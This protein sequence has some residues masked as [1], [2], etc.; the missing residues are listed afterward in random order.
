MSRSI[1][2]RAGFD[3]LFTVQFIG[4]M[5]G[6]I[7]KMAVCSIL[8]S[9]GGGN[10]AGLVPYVNALFIL[11]FF[12]FSALAGEICDRFPGRK[13]VRTVKLLE[14]P[15]SL[16]AVWSA[17]SGSTVMMLIS[18]FLY[19]TAATFFSPA[20]Y[21]LIPDNAGKE[22]LLKANAAVSASTYVSI[23]LGLFIGSF[24]A[25]ESMRLTAVMVLPAV[26]LVSAAASFLVRSGSGTKSVRV[27]ANFLR[28]LFTGLTFGRRDWRIFLAILGCSWFWLVASV[29]SIMFQT[30]PSLIFSMGP[31]DTPAAVCIL[32]VSVAAGVAGGSV[33]SSVLLKGRIS[34]RLVPVSALFTAAFL[35]DAALVCLGESA[36]E[37]TAL[38][39]ALRSFTFW[40]TAAD[41]FL[42]AFGGSMFMVPLNTCLQSLPKESE[43]ARVIASGNIWNSLFMVAGSLLCSLS[44]VSGSL[45]AA[46]ITVSLVTFLIAASSAFFI[47]RGLTRKAALLLLR[48][49][50]G[51]RIAGLP[52]ELLGKG[53][54]III[55]NH[56]SLLDGAILW[57]VL[58]DNTSFAIDRSMTGIWWVKPFLAFS[59]FYRV[60]PG[61]GASLRSL[62]E[63]VSSGKN[64]VIFPEGRITVT[65][66]MMDIYPGAGAAAEK[67]GAMIVPLHIAGGEY[68]S[69]GHFR[70]VSGWKVRAVISLGAGTP[71]SYPEG[72]G[73]EARCSV[74]RE[75]MLRAAAESDAALLGT[76]GAGGAALRTERRFG[77]GHVIAEQDGGA[78]C[79]LLYFRRMAAVASNSFYDP[80]MKNGSAVLA[81]SPFCRMV[82]MSVFIFAGADIWSGHASGSDHAFAASCGSEPE[83]SIPLIPAAGV[84]DAMGKRVRGVY[85]AVP[86]LSGNEFIAG[87]MTEGSR[88]LDLASFL[89]AAAGLTVRDAAL[90]LTEDSAVSSAA[91]IS[92]LISGAL[93][94]TLRKFSAARADALLYER[95]ASVLIADLDSLRALLGRSSALR[96]G[97]VRLAAVFCRKAEAGEARELLRELSLRDLL[98]IR[99]GDG[100]SYSSGC[101]FGDDTVRSVPR[102]FVPN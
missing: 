10:G 56:T 15:L 7:L 5:S 21:A 32:I 90:L 31:E 91:F 2:L 37:G 45:A 34:V 102:A 77:S 33:S 55:S 39:G 13:A 67:T 71:F 89:R 87:E 79:S 27:H 22:N 3:A 94:L 16:L 66:G 96:L 46:F 61:D 9:S 73:R 88:V 78:S 25:D 81:D 68:S 12:L 42:A 80:L 97:S 101:L 4:A 69:F 50:W 40:R 76:L 86:Y 49:F 64:A 99:E 47:H 74:I 20:K 83:K 82:A 29:L 100:L 19:G 30:A 59:H 36:P 84:P 6:N 23:L 51:L 14:I 93:L 53:G 38:S 28:T 52:D 65:G 48:T 43:R 41:L 92:C 98:I 44:M 70:K 60:G 1:F 35:L 72:A 24:A 62:A 58:P 75:A 11:P 85:F 8:I 18:V 63:A 95:Q 54:N 26:S 17:M 57:T